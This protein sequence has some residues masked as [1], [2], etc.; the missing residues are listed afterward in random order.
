MSALI[1]SGRQTTARGGGVY[2]LLTAP[3]LLLTAVLTGCAPGTAQPPAGQSPPPP[4]EVTVR[5]PVSKSITDYEDTTGRIEAEKTVEIRARVTGY[6]D[7]FNFKDGEEVKQGAVLFEIDPRPYQAEL[8]R[9]EAVIAQAESRLNRLEQD[10]QRANN[11]RSRN[12]IGREEFDKITNDREEAEATLKSVRAARDLTKLNVEFTKVRAPIAGVVSRHFIDVGNLVKADETPLTMIVSQDPVYAYFDVDERTQLKLRRRIVTGELPA[13][14]VAARMTVAI[15]LADEAG[16]PHKGEINFVDNR[17]DTTT[18]TLHMRAIVANPRRL[19]TPG[20][21]VRVRVPI[22]DA[23]P[24]ILV[25][26]E[27]IGTDQGRKFLFV[28]DGEDKAVHRPIKI[29]KLHDGMRIVTEGLAA[30]ERVVV[31]GLQR[32]RPGAA[33]TPKIAPER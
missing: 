9:A 27:A 32:V 25:P 4:P 8:A 17:L 30:G 14:P 19:L 28:I 13:D 21:F 18:G 7:K 10:Y 31:D 26:E 6:L 29:G 3:A 12:A 24:V 20:L 5:L 23:K 1:R 16:F 22:G 2:A 15:G 11:L 33:V